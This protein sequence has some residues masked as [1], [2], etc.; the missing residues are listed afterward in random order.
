MS[1]TVDIRWPICLPGRIPI[2][3]EYQLLGALSQLIP[4]IHHDERVGIH[5]IRGIAGEPG[6]IELTRSSALTIRCASTLIPS[7]IPLSG[8]SLALGHFSVRLGVPQLFALRGVD[9][10]ASS[11]VTIKGFMEPDAFLGAVR[12]QL[13]FLSV[14]DSACVDVGNRKVRRIKG[15][16]IV[17]FQVTVSTLN[18]QESLAIQ[19]SGIGGRRRLG[20]GI[21]TPALPRVSENRNRKRYE[22][23]SIGQN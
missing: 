3:H 15:N 5:S 17:G 13:S 11:F 9:K 2:Q 1:D 16:V 19:T 18:D 21:F 23:S 20:A 14:S 7:L 12:R 8:K 22:K 10:V 6:M 4:R